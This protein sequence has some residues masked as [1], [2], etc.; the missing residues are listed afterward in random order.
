MTRLAQTE[1]TALCDLA[2]Q[3]GA[4]QP[5]LCEGWTVHDLVAHLVLRER[6]PAAVGIVVP[7]LA[8]LTDR[9]QRRLARTDFAVLVERVRTGPPAWSPFAVP[10]VDAAVNTLEFL[11]HHEDVRRAQPSWSPRDRADDAERTVW[12]ALRVPARA[13]TRSLPVGLTLEDSVTGSTLTAHEGPQAVV[14]RGRPSELALYLYG[15]R[16]QAQVELSGDEAG[17]ARLEDA[18]LGL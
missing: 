17:I 4:D 9:A 10:A 8:G 1:R 14:V 11:V 13:L 5:T 16:P 7:P 2:L 3:L 18:S 12:S 6:S 15:R